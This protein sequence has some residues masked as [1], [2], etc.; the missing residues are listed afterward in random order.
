[1]AKETKEKQEVSK[2]LKELN[3]NLNVLNKLISI[4]ISKDNILKE[5][6]KD[7]NLVD[8]NVVDK[9]KALDSYDLPDY[10]VAI[11]VGSTTASVQQQRYAAK[12][13]EKVKPP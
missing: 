11:L 4:N 3:E 13:S 12:K 2:Q 1:M 6:D 9:I 5:K 7:K 8:K 10:L